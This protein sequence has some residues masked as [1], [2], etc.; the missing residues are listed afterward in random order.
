[1]SPLAKARLQVTLEAFVNVVKFNVDN[2]RRASLGVRVVVVIALAFCA[3]SVLYLLAHRGER[4]GAEEQCR[5]KCSPLPYRMDKTLLNPFIGEAQYR[6]TRE[7]RC[8]CGN[9]P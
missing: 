6:N 2:F 3:S 7:V 8:V 4:K 1:M 5:A 9:A